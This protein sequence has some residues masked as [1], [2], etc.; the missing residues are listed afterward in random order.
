MISNDNVDRC[1][2]DVGEMDV[3]L[4]DARNRRHWKK[5]IRM[6]NL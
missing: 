5:M 6:A 3:D 4:K 1:D 2:R